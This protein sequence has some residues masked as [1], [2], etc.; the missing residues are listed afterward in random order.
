[1][2]GSK[3]FSPKLRVHTD[4]GMEGWFIH[5]SQLTCAHKGSLCST[6]YL[7]HAVSIFATPCGGFLKW[8]EYSLAVTSLIHIE[9][10]ILRNLLG[11]EN[12]YSDGSE[13]DSFDKD[14]K[15][16]GRVRRGNEQRERTKDSATSTC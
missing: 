2:T 12:V 16:R 4:W 3:R 11:Q 14:E 13:D 7:Q 15:A 8:L 10:I 5:S 1:M 6:Y 9:V